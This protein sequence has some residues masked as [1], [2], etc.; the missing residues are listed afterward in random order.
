LVAPTTT[1]QREGSW[2][3]HV[4]MQDEDEYVCLNQM[5]TIDHRRLSSKLGQIDT[6]DFKN[7]QDGFRRLYL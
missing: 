5:R 4:R 1:Q 3:V 7:V 6:D 2:H